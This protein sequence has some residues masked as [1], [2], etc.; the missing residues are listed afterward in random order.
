LTDPRLERWLDAVLATPGLTAIEDPSDAWAM[1]VE[2]ALRGVEVVR[3]FDG[4]IVDVGSG[5]GSPGLVVAA[6]LPDREVTLLDSN[7]QFIARLPTSTPSSS[8]LQA[9]LQGVAT[10]SFNARVLDGQDIYATA[11]TSPR[12]GWTVAVAIPQRVIDAPA[13]RVLIVLLACGTVA[14]VITVLVGLKLAGRLAAN[15]RRAS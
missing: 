1:L 13:W 3:A 4:P 8:S 12:T 10:G 9:A 14:L 7:K 2:D 6:N 11:V 15:Y 5:N